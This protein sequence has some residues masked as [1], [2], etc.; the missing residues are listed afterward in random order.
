[1]PG[2]IME[3]KHMLHPSYTE[4]MELING[5]SEDDTPVI[6]SRYSIVMATA[7][8]ARQIIGGQANVTEEEAMKPVSTAVK[9]LERGDIRIV[10]DDSD[11]EDEDEINAVVNKFIADSLPSEERAE[12]LREEE[13][14]GRNERIRSAVDSSIFDEA[15]DEELEAEDAGSEDSSDSSDEE[16]GSAE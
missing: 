4:L 14:G 5:D 13:A 9:E 3:E 16:D 11:M 6:N 12:E 8:R 1:M 15:E 7:K 10:R 2:L